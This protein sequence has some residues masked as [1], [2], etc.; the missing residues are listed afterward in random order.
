MAFKYQSSFAAGELDPVLRKR[1]TLDKY[2][3][4]LALLRNCYI[5]KTGG[6]VS[7]QPSKFRIET[8]KGD[9]PVLLWSHTESDYFFELDSEDLI[10]HDLSA[11]TVVVLN[12][13]LGSDVLE[14]AQ[15]SEGYL[16]AER[17]ILGIL[18]TASPYA[19]LVI[20]SAPGITSPY[21]GYPSKPAATVTSGTGTG[22]DVEYAFTIVY[23]SM[24]ESD[25]YQVAGENIPTSSS[26][27]NEFRVESLLVTGKDLADF[28]RVNMYRRPAKG[29]AY[30]F[31]GSSFS[32]TLVGG[33]L[34]RFE[35]IDYGGGQ[36]FN[37]QPPD[38]YN[39]IAEEAGLVVPPTAYSIMSS[40][41]IFYQGRMIING[42][43]NESATFASRPNIQ[44][45]FLSGDIDINFTK[46]YPINDASGIAFK[47][48]SDNNAKVLRYADIGRLAAFTTSGVYLSTNDILVPS[49]AYMIKKSDVVI[50]RK[51]APLPLPGC[52]LVVEG[53]TS[54]IIAL[55]YSTELNSLTPE[56][57][58]IFS[59]HLFKAKEVVSWAFQPGLTPLVWVVLD[60]GQLLVFTYQ[61]EQLMQAWGHYD[62]DGLYENVTVSTG[63]D[64]DKRVFVVVNRDGTRLIEEFTERFLS[65]RKLDI[66]QDQI[67]GFAAIDSYVTKC[68]AY[69][70]EIA[71]IEFSLVGYDP[72]SLGPFTLHASVAAFVNTA[73]NG[74]ADSVLR[75]FDDDGMP[76]D[77][78]VVTFTDTQ[79][80]IVTV[81]NAPVETPFT[82]LF[83]TYSV[84]DG[85]S[86]LEGKEV[87]I[88]CD[89]FV[90]ASPKNRL[91]EY[92]TVVVTGGQITLPNSKIGAIIHVGLPII[93]DFGTLNIDT[94]EQKPTTQE[95]M[96]VN[97]VYVEVHESRGF[98]V[99]G[100][101]KSDDTN[102]N[103]EDIEKRSEDVD[104][105]DDELPTIANTPQKPYSREIEVTID[106]D[107]NSNGR[108][109]GRQVDPL[110]FE[111][112]SIVPDAEIEWRG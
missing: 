65:K 111:V 39:A 92:S 105:D 14:T 93:S 6:I 81:D 56:D 41:G 77:F 70:D 64:G 80:L 96:I 107:W 108:I 4:G 61:N 87:S 55:K 33:T 12:H 58:T 17:V 31:V 103:L 86:H 74:A 62:T 101:L 44:A 67:K 100:K 68:Y 8:D 91:E 60:D 29:A 50:N 66:Y 25:F 1:T 99:G 32:K 47:N 97:K 22:Y 110:G 51:L 90:M 59:S 27:T 78:T 104:E 21:I 36:D 10:I 76:I 89:G 75:T 24:G 37:H 57:V 109:Y 18:G 73:G 9:E 102:R 13:G 43:N 15:F 2:R 28:E 98:Y 40:A 48:G 52:V 49:T 11:G 106:S 83:K 71:D 26:E 34:V 23:K 79:N 85:L 88:L 63:P 42:A 38:N 112:I 94:V 54:K 20:P 69:H 53:S 95:P 16:G 72:E 30:G 82:M 5:S 7:R 45:L 3:N 46:D 19:M 84:V 35:V